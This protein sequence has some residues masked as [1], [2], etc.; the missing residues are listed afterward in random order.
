MTGD[1]SAAHDAPDHPESEARL[2]AALAGVPEG[3]RRIA[4]EKAHPT[5]LALVHTHKHRRDPFVLQE[6]PRTGL[7]P[8]PDTYV[9]GIV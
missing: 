8:R 6:C 7:L 9:T 3:T 5:D 2:V 1:F 4:P